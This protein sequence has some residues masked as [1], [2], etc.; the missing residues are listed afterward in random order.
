[1]TDTLLILPDR[2]DGDGW[3]VARSGGR[4][5][6]RQASIATLEKDLSGSYA[7]VLPGQQVRAF[8]TDIPEKVRGS[9]R[10][11]IARF[12]HEDR[13]A[14][15]LDGLHIVVDQGATA[16]TLMVGRDVM[17]RL[18][19]QF[20]PAAIYVDFDLLTGVADEPVRLLDRIVTPGPQGDAVDPDWAEG[21]GVTLDDATLGQALL[22]GVENALDL[23]S[24]AYRRRAKIQLG[25]WRN[26]AAGL[27]VCSGLG[28]ALSWAEIRA[29]NAQTENVR[30]TARAIYTQ[31]T[32]EVA[33]E[34]LTRAIRMVGPTDS[35]PTAFLQLS[36]QLFAAMAEHPD[37]A[38]ERLS[39]D[40]Q[41]NLL[42]LRLIYPGFEAADDLEA[43]TSNMGATLQTGGVREQSGQFIGDAALTLGAGS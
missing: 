15:D 5:V 1:M 43:T 33:P 17:D 10:I 16:R 6:V 25:A 37:I 4:S 34:N 26:V 42:R 9:D 35:D 36:N 27:L 24:G 31:A 23:R 41:E 2:P 12:S 22:D 29:V 18:L 28:L 38:V 19:E 14:S 11:N 39:F 40:Q 8:L 32:G 21:S 30:E 7:L 20:H 3:L 13:V